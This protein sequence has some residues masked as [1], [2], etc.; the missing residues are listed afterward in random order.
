MRGYK[1]ANWAAEPSGQCSL[2]LPSQVITCAAN[3]LLPLLTLVTVVIIQRSC[4]ESIWATKLGLQF[5][6]LECARVVFSMDP[7]SLVPNVGLGTRL[8]V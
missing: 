8:G 2:A 3:A 1:R 6:N 5:R 4:C 7:T